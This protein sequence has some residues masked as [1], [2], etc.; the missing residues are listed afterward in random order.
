MPAVSIIVATFNRARELIAFLKR[1][2]QHVLKSNVDAQIIVVN[3]NSSDHTAQV[4]DQFRSGSVLQ[5][6]VAEEPRQGANYARNTGILHSTAPIIAF[7][8]DDVDFSDTWLVDLLDY[9]RDH[10]ECQAVTGEIIPMFAIPRPDWLIDSM[11]GY[12]GRQ[13]Y[14][15]RSHDLKF[16]EFPVEMNMAIRAEVL[17]KHGGFSTEFSRDAK[18]LMSN[19]GKI[20]FYRVAQSGDIVRYIP[21]ARLYH[22]IP[23]ERIEPRWIIRRHFWQGVSDIAFQQLIDP[24]RRMQDQFGAV[25]DLLK[26]INRLRGKNISPRRIY[27]HLI[28]LNTSSR[29]RYAYQLGAISRRLGWN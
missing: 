18:T 24:R 26:L 14:G 2:E 22:L 8:D 21:M 1:L 16:P 17:K 19:D 29:A 28:N 10:P 15:A 9:L 4:L 3:N 20:F 12:Y 27:W 13:S 11:L 6:T 7:T 23:V 25:I 5:I